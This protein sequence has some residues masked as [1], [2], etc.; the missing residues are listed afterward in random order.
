M[1]K[2][3]FKNKTK[4]K[5]GEPEVESGTTSNIPTSESKGCQKE[6]RKSKKLKAYLKK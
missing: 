5:W 6:E 3:E 1:K 2:Q 4:K